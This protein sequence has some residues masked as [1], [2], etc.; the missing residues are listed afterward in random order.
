[1]D[2]VRDLD[3]QDTYATEL[4][5]V[6]QPWVRRLFELTPDAVLSES[7]A[8]WQTLKQSAWTFAFLVQHIARE[9]LYRPHES[10]TAWARAELGKDS[11]A[12]SKY[13]QSAEFVLSL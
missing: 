2:P 3:T 11:G 4:P 1:M 5:D 10:L 9:G 7:R 8:C 12:V 6:S 13:R